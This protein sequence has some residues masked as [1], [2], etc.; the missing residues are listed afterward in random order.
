MSTGNKHFLV[1]CG[2]GTQERLAKFGVSVLRINH[3]FISHLHGDHYLG[4][5]GL[6]FTMHL[7][8]RS[9]ELHIY[10]QRGLEEIILTHLKYSESVLNY[11]L[12]FNE[13]DAERSTKIYEDKTLEVTTIPLKHRIACSGFV[14]KE[15]P[16]QIRLNKEKLPKDISLVSIG[17]LKKGEDVFDE[18]G[19]ILYRNKDMTL[20][21]RP[22]YSYAFCSD[23]CYD[24]GI[25]PYVQNVDLLYHE[26][27]FLEDRRRWAEITFHST[28][29]DAAKIADKANV[30]QLVIGHYSARYKDLGP[31]LDEA[32]EIFPNTILAKEGEIIDIGR[33][34]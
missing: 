29:H 11:P 10:G 32:Q 33:Q 22:S 12:V 16:K 6:L 9:A 3:I 4:L 19:N 13:L 20:P 5:M 18:N 2:E 21:P 17:K 28:T 34:P 7:L 25:I 27:T 8:K 26:A 31:F 1:D 24:E 30:K 23:T 15:K 14:F